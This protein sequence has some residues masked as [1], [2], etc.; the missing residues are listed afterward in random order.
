VNASISR[1]APVALAA[2]AVACGSSTPAPADGCSALF[3]RPNAATGL[4]SAQCGPSCA[5]N[6]GTFTSPVYG[7]PLLASLETGWTLSAPYAP[8]TSDPYLGP[9]PTPDADGTVCAVIPEA[10]ATT[11]PRPYRLE[12]FATAAA[13]QAAGGTVTH[14]GRCGV[15]STLPN[16]AVYIR[17]ED[18]TAPVR[19]CGL[20]SFGSFDRDVACL[21]DL[22]FDLPCAQIWAYN[23]GHT[24]SACGSICLSLLDAP[25]NNPD[26]SLN[27]CLACD[28]QQ[29]GPVFKAVAGRTR[30]NSGLANAICR[31]C[32]EVQPL[33]H[34]Y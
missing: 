27:A 14:F 17:H 12:T 28:E 31:P 23:T 7:E 30:R 15:C 2:L 13:A 22:G 20:G 4:T 26:G 5:C 32:S 33:V 10:S 16:L 34:S 21:M 19:A 25:Y 29:S 1:L 9:A 6:G 11:S 3:G 24:S 18:L 8:L